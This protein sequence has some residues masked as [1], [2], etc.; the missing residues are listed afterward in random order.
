MLEQGLIE[1]TKVLMAMNLPEDCT[2]MQAIAYK[3]IIAALRG[4]LDLDTAI[5][6][7]KQAS[8]RYAKR[9]LTWL[10]RDASVDWILW[11]KTPDIGL[12]LQLSTNYICKAL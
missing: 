12:G 10:R 3:E 6:D 5:A 8:R 9:Q 11:D 4:E 2:A 7:L 1:E